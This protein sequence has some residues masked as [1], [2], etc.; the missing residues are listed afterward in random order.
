MKNWEKCT[1]T[2]VNIETADGLRA[3]RQIAFFSGLTRRKTNRVNAKKE[4]QHV[5]VDLY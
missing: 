4:H 5:C 1:N 3:V 2:N